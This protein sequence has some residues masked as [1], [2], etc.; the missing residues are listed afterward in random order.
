MTGRIRIVPL[1]SQHLPDAALLVGRRYAALRHAFPLMPTAWEDPALILPMLISISAAPGAAAFVGDRLVGFLAGWL[2]PSLRGQHAVYSPEW[3]NAAEDGEHAGR[4]YQALY[5]YMAGCWAAAGYPDHYLTVF[6]HDRAGLT[7]W[8]WCGF[9]YYV[10]DALRPL[11]PAQ[12]AHTPPGVEIRRATLDD[13]DAAAVLRR[14]LRNHLSASPIFLPYDENESDTAWLETWLADPAHA[15]WMAWRDGQ[16]IAEIGIGPASED[17]CTVIRDAGT[18]SI[19]SGYTLPG[20]RGA[21]AATAVLNAALDWACA[22]GYVRCC[23]DF[24]A[25][26]VPGAAFWLRHFQP[27]CYSFYRH[28]NENAL[29]T[30][31]TARVE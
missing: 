21:G 7:G 26:N 2:T 14:G 4:I 17:A 10:I 13:V 29:R 22:A 6:A 19:T 11:T 25:M 20:E 28:V 24:E 27:V 30:S 23:V 9:G 16:A 1:E 8:Q 5:T 15:L 3:A 31:M 12:P 18:A